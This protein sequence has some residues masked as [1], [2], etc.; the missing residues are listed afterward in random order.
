MGRRMK[1]PCYV[2]LGAGISG[3]S[4]GWFLKQKFKDSIDINILEASDT[5]GSWIHTEFKDNFLFEQGPRSFRSSGNGAEN[6]AL[7]ESLEMQNDVIFADKA[8]AKRFI[9]SDG[10]IC[11]LPFNPLSMLFS[12]FTPTIIKAIVK[13]FRAPKSNQDDESIYSFISRRFGVSVAE[14]IFD[15]M[16]AGI[17]AGDTKQLSIKSCFPWLHHLEKTYGSVFKGFFAE[18]NKK[19][20]DK[21]T[22]FV[23]ESLKKG[24]F[25]L[26]N[27]VQSLTLKLKQNLNDALHLNTEAISIEFKDGKSIVSTKNHQTF[28]AD[29][30]FVA[31]PAPIYGSLI[32]KDYP[33]LAKTLKEIQSTSLCVVNLGFNS[34]VLKHSGFG[35]LI[36][37][38][39]KQYLLGAAFDSCAF[40]QQNA[41]LNQ[42]RVTV[43]IGGSHFKDFEEMTDE[44]LIEMALDKFAKHTEVKEKPECVMLKRAYQA[45]PQYTVGHEARLKKIENEQKKIPAKIA[46]LGSGFYG[47]SVNDCIARAKAV[48]LD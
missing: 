16:V 46:L 14:K 28:V 1:K 18:R 24:L 21:H 43:M 29:K 20:D 31:I 47:I 13:D 4:L 23:E 10:K 6:L 34:K 36:P 2:I 7:I 5:F 32:E 33:E 42:T 40:P 37:S 30:L 11:H 22:P 26:K 9:Y 35:Y 3:L 19:S 15:P 27:G 8:A 41:H 45:I 39:E 25:T 38:I 12:K 44:Q 48:S 17:Y